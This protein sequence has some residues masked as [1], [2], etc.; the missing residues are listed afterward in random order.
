MNCSRCGLSLLAP[1]PCERFAPM[2]VRLRLLRGVVVVDTSRPLPVSERAQIVSR[3]SE[4]PVIAISVRWG[5]ANPKLASRPI[6]E[7][8]GW[9]PAKQRYRARAPVSHRPAYAR[10]VGTPCPVSMDVVAGESRLVWTRPGCGAAAVGPRGSRKGPSG[11]RTLPRRGCPPPTSPSSMCYPRALGPPAAVRFSPQCQSRCGG[12]Q[13][14]GIPS[15]SVFKGVKAVVELREH[16][17]RPLRKPH[18]FAAAPFQAARAGRSVFAAPPR[19]HSR[20]ERQSAPHRRGS[21]CWG[22]K[23][24]QQRRVRRLGGGLAVRIAKSGQ[25][26]CDP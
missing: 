11:V 1:E 23:R 20:A 15:E 17:A 3:R 7:P 18:R 22:E 13:P 12:G 10:N 5:S 21:R 14:P 24:C 25:R 2:I 26:R 16:L 4:A 8:A 19:F 6:G 9:G